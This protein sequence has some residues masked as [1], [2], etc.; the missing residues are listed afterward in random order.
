MM[1]LL[2]LFADLISIGGGFLVS[3]LSLGAAPQVY[4]QRTVE[5]IKLPI[6]LPLC[7]EQGAAMDRAAATLAGPA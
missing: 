2:V 1:P 4:L 5:S 6:F 3:T 7:A